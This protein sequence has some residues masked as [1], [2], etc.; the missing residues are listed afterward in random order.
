MIR[1]TAF[2]CE[3]ANSLIGLGEIDDVPKSLLAAERMLE[4][5]KNSHVETKTFN[6][7]AIEKSSKSIGITSNVEFVKWIRSFSHE[8]LTPILSAVY[9]RSQS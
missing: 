3:L 1:L 5:I 8:E 6:N 7:K 2:K 9:S 4:F